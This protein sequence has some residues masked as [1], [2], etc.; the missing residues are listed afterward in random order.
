MNLNL[1]RFA[2]GLLRQAMTRI[3]GLRFVASQ[4]DMVGFAANVVI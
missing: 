2:P 4:R 3:S 1:R